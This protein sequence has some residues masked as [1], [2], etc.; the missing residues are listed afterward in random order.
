MARPIPD[1]Q[2]VIS[3]EL[4]REAGI[5]RTITVAPGTAIGPR[6]Q[7]LLTGDRS[8]YVEYPEGNVVE[9]WDFFARRRPIEAL[10]D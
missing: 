4:T 3:T 10:S 8:L 9:V 6:R 1:E 2:P 5:Q 7:P